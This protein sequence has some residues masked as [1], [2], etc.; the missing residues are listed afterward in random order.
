M[1]GRTARPL[2]ADAPVAVRR[3]AALP[4]GR[5]TLGMKL[6]AIYQRL[7]RLHRALGECIQKRLAAAPQTNL[8]TP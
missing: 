8:E 7:A 1:H 4:R 2:T 3:G 6:D 5:P